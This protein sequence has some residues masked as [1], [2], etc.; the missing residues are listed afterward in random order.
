LFPLRPRPSLP[1]AVLWDMDGTLVDTE[2]YWIAAEQR[3]VERHG[4]GGWTEGDGLA[5]VG[6]DLR[7]SARYIRKHGGVN[8][9]LDDIVNHLLDS[10]IAK[11]RRQ[12]P[13]RPGARRLLD[14]LRREGVPCALVTMSWR[15][16]VD[17]VV[18]GLPDG[19]FDS[20]V[21]G[22]DVEYGK[23]HPEPYLRAAAELGVAPR[24]CVALEDSPTGVQS[25]V[26]AGC[27]VI[28]IPHHV[29]IPPTTGVRR[30]G[31]LSDL[32]PRSLLPSSVFVKRRLAVGAAAVVALVGIGG[33]VWGR[34]SPSQGVAPPPIDI[35]VDAW[36][37]YW[38]LQDA[39]NSL[40]VHGRWLRNVSPFWYSTTGADQIVVDGKLSQDRRSEFVNKIR[41]RG[42]KVIPSIIDA[43]SAGEMAAIL[44]DP[45][46]RTTH[47]DTIVALV[48]NNDF[49]GIDLDYEKFAFSDS[50]TTWE[51]TRPNWVAFVA[52][53]GER[54]HADGRSLVVSV[55]Y[56][57]DDGQTDSS[58]Y[59]VYDYAGMAPHVDQ[60]RMMAYDYSTSAPGPIAPLEFVRRA[61]AGAKQTVADHS[62]LVLGIP[63][64]G[65]NW[66][67]DEEGTC[68]GSDGTSA[69]NH[70]SIGELIAR[71]NAQSF[72][73]SVTSEAYFTYQIVDGSCTQTRE[74]H[75][76]DEEGARARIDLAR[77]E[78]LG[79][80]SLWALGF[81]SPS[82][83]DAIAALARTGIGAF[84]EEP[85]TTAPTS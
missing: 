80:V 38:A 36:A 18:S 65:R 43:T 27:Q 9:P 11:V 12:I 83:W 79:G 53:L 15:R 10:V 2:P 55:P 29:E 17:A 32:S 54:L 74:V 77:R 47:V 62:K 71:R 69:V 21:V 33:L 24:R 6:L 23:P 7:D 1:G 34:D 70:R 41:S 25:A 8:L 45:A 50:R 14:E 72:R 28:A 81:D 58:G 67:V 68:S 5:L 22:D 73:D 26:A 42:G 82:T 44:A 4:H 49:D 13:W 57:F 48:A 40:D 59:W 16:L 56:I 3:L 20:V 31:S 51:T 46:S 64:Y 78:R 76:V 37:P 84:A 61:I 85:V 39:Q 35:P 30:I 63:L 60:I 19:T 75:Y 66:L 52:E